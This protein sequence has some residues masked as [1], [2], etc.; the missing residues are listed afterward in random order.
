[1]QYNFMTLIYALLQICDMERVCYLTVLCMMKHTSSDTN[2]E[3]E[4]SSCV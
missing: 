2:I 1:M 3:C 4:I